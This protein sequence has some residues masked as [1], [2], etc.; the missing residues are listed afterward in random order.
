MCVERGEIYMARLYQDGESSLQSGIRPVLIVSNNKANEF[1][2]VITVLPLTSKLKKRKLP[3]HVF[4]EGCGI[5]QSIVLVEQIMSLDQS[6]LIRKMGRLRPEFNQAIKRAI[7]IQL[8][9]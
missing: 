8:S 2:P 3:T 6:R 1:S 9:L 4:V 5:R 7:E